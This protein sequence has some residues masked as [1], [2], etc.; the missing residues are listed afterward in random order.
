MTYKIDIINNA[1]SQLR[2]SG[3]LTSSPSPG[4]IDLALD[5][6]ETMAHEYL[7]RNI[8]VD[9]NF[10]D[11][12]DTSSLHNIDRKF[13]YA[14]ETGL[15]M[16]LIADYGKTIPEALKMNHQSAFSMLS[17]ATVKTRMLS[18]P[19][20]MPI[21]RGNRRIWRKM[22]RYYPATEKSDLSCAVSTKMYIDDIRDFTECFQAY[23]DDLE[24]IVSYTLEADDGLEIISESLSSPDITYRVKALSAGIQK[25][26]IIAT[27]QT[28]SDESLTDGTFYAN[29]TS[30]IDA[31]WGSGSFT[32]TGYFG[33]VIND[34]GYL[35]LTGGI[36]K[37]ASYDGTLNVPD[38]NIGCIRIKFIPNYSGTPTSNIAIFSSDDSS[39][40]QSL[41]YIYHDSVAGDLTAVY[42]T[43]SGVLIGSITNTFSPVSGETYEIEF[44]WDFTAGNTQLFLDGVSQ[45]TD[46]SLATTDTRTTLFVGADNVATAITDCYIDE[47]VVF[48]TVQHLTDYT[49]YEV[50]TRIE[51]REK[52]IQ[53]IEASI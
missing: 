45:G 30:N 51:T 2:I 19:S 29:Y 3:V 4:E 21:G 49:P 5:R 25:I 20:R 11:E 24:E 13:W 18:Y 40:D 32:G 48:S 23:L 42:F 35:D 15:A 28:V 17:N 10:E 8:C 16:R 9:Y 43:D 36:V 52:E 53:V 31:A 33:A 1:Y 6:L 39:T 34:D 22:W 12:P 27:A 38:G 41:I 26:K 46:V 47:I 14:F 50:P 37:Y 44:N 7:A